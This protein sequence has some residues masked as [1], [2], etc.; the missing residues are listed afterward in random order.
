MYICYFKTSEFT[1]VCL[2]NPLIQKEQLGSGRYGAVYTFS[3][4]RKSYAG[5]MIHKKLLPGYP[6]L[7]LDQINDLKENLKTASVWFDDNQHSNVEVFHSLEQLSDTNSMPLI[8]LTELLHENLNTHTARMRGNLSS[9]E[10]LKLCHDMAKGLQ[11]LHNLRV[12]HSNLHGANVLI[13]QD[14]QA[15]VA[16][17]ICPQIDTLNE[18]TVSQFEVYRSPES[19]T[20]TKAVTQKSDIYSLGALYL[21]VATQNPPLPDDSF[22]VFEVQRWKKQMDEI[23]NNPLQPLI[24][25]CFDSSE[26]RPHIDEICSKIYHLEVNNYIPAICHIYSIQ[27]YIPY[28]IKHS[29]R[30]FHGFH[31]FSQPL[32]F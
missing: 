7:S 23:I 13:S 18:N 25:Q 32:M 15:K 22:E 26:T 8:L 5:K 2:Q 9:K 19:I 10:Q 27:H 14:G 3:Y 30:N 4:C 20:N 17:Y 29:G 11:F 21:Q 12:V 24:A 1:Y 6:N 31:S 16:D 28:M